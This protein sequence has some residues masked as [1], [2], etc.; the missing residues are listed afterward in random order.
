MQ[1]SDDAKKAFP[2]KNN[3]NNLSI[4][5]T[6]Y[7]ICLVR[8]VTCISEMLTI[9]TGVTPIVGDTPHVDDV[10]VAQPISPSIERAR[11][12]IISCGISCVLSINV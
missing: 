1:T 7:M 12:A 2:N 6:S 3:F 10:R 8:C 4:E 11:S 5:M 9:K